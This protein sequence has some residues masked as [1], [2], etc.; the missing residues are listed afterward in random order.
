MNKLPKRV[1]NINGGDFTFL[2]G[3]SIKDV[4]TITTDPGVYM[5]TCSDG[6]KITIEENEGCGGCDN[7]WSDISNITL[8]EKTDNVITNV[9]TK[10]SDDDE[11]RFTLFIFY[12]DTTFEIEGNDGYGNG[13]YGGGFEVK[14]IS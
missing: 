6:C 12:H 7:G 2:I 3:K 1:Y 14:I 11:D 10:Y 8:L 9:K 4:A 5:L 13:Y